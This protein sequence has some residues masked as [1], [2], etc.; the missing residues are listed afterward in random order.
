MQKLLGKFFLSSLF[1]TLIFCVTLPT[2][3]AVENNYFLGIGYKGPAIRL[4]QRILNL[5]LA[6]KVSLTGD[7][8]LGKETE[9]LG[10]KTSSALLKFQRKYSIMGEDGRIG[11]QTLKMIAFLGPKMIDAQRNKKPVIPTD[12]PEAEATTT[13]RPTVKSYSSLPVKQQTTTFVAKSVKPKLSSLS[14]LSVYSGQ[15]VTIWGEGFTKTGNNVITKFKTI[16]NI[17]SPDGKTLVFNFSIPIDDKDLSTINS[18]P[19]GAV[20]SFAVPIPF[21]V[22][23]HNGQSNELTFSYQLR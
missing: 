15:T 5:D 3:E 16:N 22:E 18:L 7:G 23:N 14:P 19:L 12:W 21:Y 2:V 13:I 8:S 9:Y 1:F 6:T 10:Q 4:V 17:P 11:P 20:D